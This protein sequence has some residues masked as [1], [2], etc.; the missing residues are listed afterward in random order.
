MTLKAVFDTID[1]LDDDAIKNLY[2]QVTVKGTDGKEKQVYALDIEGGDALP[3]VA[4]L[5]NAHERQKAENQTLR[6][7]V[8]ELEGKVVN[9]PDNFSQEE[10]DRLIALDNEIKKGPLDDP[11]KKK[12]HEAEVQSIKTMHEQALDRIRKKS[13]ADLKAERDAHAQTKAVLRNRVVGDDLTKALVENGVDKRYLPMARA[14]LEKSVKVKEDN[15]NLIAVVETDLGETPIAEF[16][17]QWVQSEQGKLVVPQATG[18]GATGA[19]G[20]SG[21]GRLD[22]TNPWT[23]AHWNAT[24][25]G[26]IYK[27][28]QSR[29]DRLAQAAGHKNVA[30]ARRD[31]AKDA[32]SA[33]A[34]SRRAI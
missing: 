10:W 1:D 18:S 23:F 24:Q 4:P 12:Q 6:T 28:D 33:E 2:K 34:M 15:A 9:L 21:G 17:P 5:R 8:Q 13:E 32:P 14:F 19:G 27:V 20:N 26:Q 31:R 22:S 30:T 16:V 3:F 11:E 25:Q 7:K 29:A